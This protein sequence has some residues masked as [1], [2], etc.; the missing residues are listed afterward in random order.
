MPVAMHNPALRLSLITIAAMP[1]QSTDLLG[2]ANAPI[3]AQLPPGWAVRPVRGYSAPAVQVL[4]DTAGKL[5]QVSGQGEAG[6]FHHEL[7]SPIPEQTGALRWS[8]RVLESP[9]AADLRQEETDDSPIRVFVV[10]GRPGLLGRS[11]RI[12]F[13]SY[14]GGEPA[15]YARRSHGSDRAQVIRVDGRSD[16]GSWRDHDVDPFADYRRAWGGSPRPIAAVGFM[17]DTD[18]TRSRA[19]AALRRLEWR[20]SNAFPD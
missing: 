10:F 16:N 5:L 4:G 7:P 11:A 19:V 2:V 3:G 15:G 20:P 12:I 17:Q 13:Y 6:W 14:G 1:I 18:Q 9:A 8:W